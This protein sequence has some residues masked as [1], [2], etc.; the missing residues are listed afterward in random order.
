[1]NSIISDKNV[2]EGISILK[3]NDHILCG[4]INIIGDFTLIPRSN[5]FESLVRIVIGQQLSVSAARS[6]SSRL[7]EKLRNN[8]TPEIVISTPD[9]LFFD[10]GLSQFKTQ[11]V[12]TISQ[13]LIQNKLNL[14]RISK[15]TNEDIYQILIKIKG[16]GP[17]T[18]Q[19][20]LIFVLG[21]INIIPSNDLAFLKAV[22][23]NYY[24]EKLPT[25][26]EIDRIT[27]NWKDYET[28]AAWY[29]WE[30][31]NRKLVK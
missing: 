27:N 19:N 11:T 31:I 24:L 7:K 9:R 21:R 1:M 26:V 18:I 5:S 22:K 4:I 28:I 16:V 23:L 2:N 3:K 12:R 25:R 30:T 6:I 14:E 20:Y 15:M 17:W 13:E 8:I 29:L 10:A